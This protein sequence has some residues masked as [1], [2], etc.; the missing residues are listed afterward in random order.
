M[1]NAKW[2]PLCDCWPQRTVWF[3]VARL[4]HNFI[5]WISLN[6]RHLAR[7]LW[8]HFAEYFA[9]LV[10]PAT[11]SGSTTRTFFGSISGSPGLGTTFK[12][13]RAAI[14]RPAIRPWIR[15]SL[16]D[17]MNRLFAQ[18]NLMFIMFQFLSLIL[19]NFQVDLCKVNAIL[20][21]LNE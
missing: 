9:G 18:C 3:R 14:K 17:G 4:L 2:L 6:A 16:I 15:S 11:L 21:Q 7:S 8:K 5:H 19:S 1:E 13:C 10:W 20:D 12:W